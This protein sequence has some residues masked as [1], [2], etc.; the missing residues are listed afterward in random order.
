MEPSSLSHAKEQWIEDVKKALKLETA[1]TLLKNIVHHQHIEAVSQGISPSMYQQQTARA[2]RFLS[3]QNYSDLKKSKMEEWITSPSIGLR[4]KQLEDAK[5]VLSDSAVKN[6]S[7]F[8]SQPFAFELSNSDNDFISASKDQV[9]HLNMGWSPSSF[10]LTR[11][12]ILKRPYKNWDVIFKNEQLHD[13]RVRWFYLSSASYQWAGAEAHSEIA[14][15][16]SLAFDTVQ[17]FLDLGYTVDQVIPR[18]TFGLSMG[19]DV[20]IESAKVTALKQVWLKVCELFGGTLSADSIEVY[21]LPS[22]RCFSGRDPWNNIMR[23]TLMSFSAILGGAHGFKCIPYDVL[24]AQKDPEALR[25]STNIPLLLTQEGVLDRVSN[26]FDGSPLFSQTVDV[27]CQQAWR[28]FKD[29]EGKGGIFEAIRSGWLQS[30]VRQSAERSKEEVAHLS[31]LILG[32]NKFVSQNVPSRSS[33]AVVKLQ[34]IIDPLFLKKNE[35]DFLSVEPLIVEALSYP[36]EKIQL[37]MDDY[38]NKNETYPVVTVVK[39]AGPISEKRMEW[40]KMVLGLAPFSIQWMTLDDLSSDTKRRLS[41]TRVTLVLPSSAEN[42]SQILTAL[43][44]R[45]V[46]KVWYVGTARAEST[47][48]GYLEMTSNALEFL[49]QL[50]EDLVEM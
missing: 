35:D 23:L 32:V 18:I 26:P 27:L 33:T 31:K 8:L 38:K 24:R 19:T 1:P 21:A 41:P 47:F 14:I 43:R 7:L 2:S 6:K 10:G 17:E 48:D 13:P 22:L 42:E 40:L 50:Q 46:E 9:D 45:K 39:G 11:G 37:R 4:F 28:A 49:K 3:V 15:L 20:L 5:I 25:V 44:E 12:E 30:D 34:D 16:A 29:I 36:W